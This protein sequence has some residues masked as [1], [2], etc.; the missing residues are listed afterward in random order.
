MGR[1]IETSNLLRTKLH[2]S[3]L[4]D[5]LIQ[6]SHLLEQLNRGFQRRATLAS[7][8]MAC[9]EPLMDQES[10]YLAAL[11][12]ATEY[13]IEGFSLSITYPGGTLLFY[14]QDGPR[15]RRQNVSHVC[16]VTIPGRTTRYRTSAYTSNRRRSID[17]R[18]HGENAAEHCSDEAKKLLPHHADILA[19]LPSPA[20]LG[21]A[22]P[23]SRS[24]MAAYGQYTG[25]ERSR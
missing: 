7:T 19:Q 10:L 5:D 9:D 2:R 24:K 8:M 18:G 15:P 13:T 12:S 20:I 6:R 1:Q 4:A 17:C 23:P 14:D 21:G 22:L 11:E 3:R 25:L 16:N